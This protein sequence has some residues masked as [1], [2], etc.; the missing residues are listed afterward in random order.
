M[1]T[2]F[3]WQTEE[4][5][6]DETP[7]AQEKAEQTKRRWWPQALVALLILIAVGI[8]LYRQ[9]RRQ[10]DAAVARTEADVRRT[11]ELVLQAADH[12]DRDLLNTM[13]SARD[14]SWLYQQ[15]EIAEEGLLYNPRPF[16][17][18]SQPNTSLHHEF[19]LS[20]DLNEV[21]RNRPKRGRL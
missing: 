20:P 9:V 17:L 1:P 7:V 6:W 11:H 21:R 4:D 5:R 2:D 3:N 18:V 10:L 12:S 13:L 8:L 19:G 14:E 16:G 15:L